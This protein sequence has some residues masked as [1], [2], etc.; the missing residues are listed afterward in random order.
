MISSRKS[1]SQST[2]I[3]GGPIACHTIKVE[4]HRD[5]CLEGLDHCTEKGVPGY[6]HCVRQGTVERESLPKVGNVAEGRADGRR[7]GQEA[8]LGLR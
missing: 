6:R 3:F 4:V 1:V 5:L 2:Y 8:R 7:A